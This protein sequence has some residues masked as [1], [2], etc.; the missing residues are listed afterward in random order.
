MTTQHDIRLGVEVVAFTLHRSNQRTLGITVLPDG[1]I[2]V[3]APENASLEEIEARVRR[4]GGWIL[5][6]RREF[7][8]FRPRMTPRRFVSGETHRYLGRQ[9]RLSV[10]PDARRGVNLEGGFLIV[11]GTDSSDTDGIKRSVQG[12]YR[13]MARAIF[14]DRLTACLPLFAAE[15]LVAPK[16]TLRSLTRRWGSMSRDGTSLVLNTRLVEAP[17]PWIDYVIVHELC[18]VRY[19]N[20][21]PEFVDLLHSKMPDWMSR[22]AKLEKAL[23]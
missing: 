16:L 23:A 3:S 9:L 6:V 14:A 13:R 2:T 4:R 20:H 22:K 11:G 7:E 15:H 1:A 5:R 17:L 21:G 18:H 8:A 19:P 10:R 12:W